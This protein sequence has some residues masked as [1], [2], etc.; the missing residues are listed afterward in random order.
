ML[1]LPDLH[2]G[3]VGNNARCFADTARV[4]YLIY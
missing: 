2:S 3:Y 4:A 1:F